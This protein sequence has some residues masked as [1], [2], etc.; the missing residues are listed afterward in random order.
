[1]AT[2]PDPADFSAPLELG[3]PEIDQH[4]EEIYSL[5]KRIGTTSADAYRPLDDDQVD[6]VLDILSELRDA[7]MVHFGIEEAYMVE[8]DYPDH[9]DHATAHEHFIDDL[10]RYEMELMNGSA[11]PP[12]TIRASMADWY[13]EHILGMDK[14]FGDFYKKSGK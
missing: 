5:L 6:A 1:M 9:D 4:H 7:A 8:A 2:K 11:I 10:S 14:P 3:I 13:N 12:V